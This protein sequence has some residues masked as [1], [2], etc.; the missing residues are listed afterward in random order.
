MIRGHHTLRLG[1]AA[2]RRLRQLPAN[3]HRWRSDLL[4][5]IVDVGTG[6]QWAPATCRTGAVT[7]K[8]SPTSC[9]VTATVRVL[10]SATRP[11]DRWLSPVPISGKQTYRA[12]YFGDTWHVTQQADSEHWRAL[13]TARAMVGALR[14]DDLLQSDSNELL[15][16]RLQRRGRERLSGR[17]VPGQDWRQR[18]PE[19]LAAFQDGI[20]ASPWVS[21]TRS[22]Q[23]GDSRRLRNL[24]HSELCL[25]QRQPLRR[26]GQQRDLELLLQQRPRRDAR[27]HPQRQHLY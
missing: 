27:C 1:Y 5:R 4:R 6:R 19:Q 12:F 23:D 25:V 17:S 7:A 14:Q 18:Q 26:S 22:I 9:S 11:A 2:R 20:P 21:P 16:N 3:Q 15:S 13:R 24:L 10:R 8:I